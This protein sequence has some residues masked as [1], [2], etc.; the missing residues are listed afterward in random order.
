MLR[1]VDRGPTLAELHRHPYPGDEPT[2]PTPDI[3]T[4]RISIETRIFS[5]SAHPALTRAICDALGV[6][7]APSKTSR[8][9]D[10]ETFFAAGVNV[11][12]RHVY[13]V[14]PTCATAWGSGNDSLMEL[15]IATSALRLSSAASI[16][17]VIPYLGYARQDRKV[18]PRTPITAAL[19]ADLLIAAGV[20]RVIT[21]DLH[22]AQ[23]Q[24]FYHGKPVDNLY[25]SYVLVPHLR[26]AGYGP[27]T[28]VV[29]P[30]AGGVPRARAYA[31]HLGAGDLAIIDKRRERANECE[32]MNII[33]DVAGR[34][35]LIIDDMIDTAGTLVKAA[36]ALTRA[37]AA[38]VS[39][40]AT[41]GVLSPPALTRIAESP[42]REVILTDSIPLLAA[43]VEEHPGAMEKLRVV[44]LAPLLA[45][46]IRCV[47]GGDSVSA[48]F[49][50]G[51]K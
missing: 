11:R 20:D 25:A 10:G 37:G 9:A 46:A 38:S 8:F 48:L 47:D 15:L 51:G 27:E 40:C 3:L 4:P 13:F 29:S 39:A 49:A 16:T 34:D 14:Q 35:C 5:G 28:K 18:T 36:E 21:V 41:H 6:E 43:D 23:I 2:M 12:G 31:Q 45:E 17:A 7:V 42:L 50:G 30:D 22:A 44:S 1:S 24:G 26:A 33:G 32:V 19:V